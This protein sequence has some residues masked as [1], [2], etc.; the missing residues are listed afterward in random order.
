[1]REKIAVVVPIYNVEKYLRRC[2]D[3]I[4]VQTYSNLEI[5]LVNDGS[6]DMSAEICKE[7]TT[8]DS[9]IKLINKI[10]GGLSD[11]R[12]VGVQSAESDY[13]IFID[14]DDY[15]DKTCI[16]DLV[17]LKDRT[18]SEIA[19]TPLIYEFENGSKKNVS[20]FDELLLENNEFLALVMHAKYGIG[21]SV[22]SKLF[23]KHVLLKHPFPKGKLHEDLAVSMDLYGE[24]KK[25]AISDKASYHYIQRDTSI[26]HS[27]IDEKSLFWIIDYIK[28]LID[29][30]NNALLKQALVYR[31][32]DL[33]NEYCRVID[34]NKNKQTIEKIQHYIRPYRNIYLRDSDNSIT[35][36]IKGFLIS[37]NKIT[38]RIFLKLKTLNLK[39]HG[40]K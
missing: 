33:V 11:A 24:F 32:F 38:F 10:N 17:E 30:E 13:I 16:L 23:P 26:M 27:T 5:I 37:T 36:K 15:I 12:N 2:I 9:R 1:M 25:A 31:I 8:K 4:L 7:Y 39:A 28:E 21:V 20:S 34:I 14:S 19:C 40:Y 35:T 29:K 3:S 22:C 6:Q 18:N